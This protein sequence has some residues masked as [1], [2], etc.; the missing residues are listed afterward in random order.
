MG[1]GI[2]FI[3]YFI[4][5]LMSLHKYGFLCRIIGYYLIF[6]SLQKLS[7]YKR[8]LSLAVFPLLIMTLC[9]VYDAGAMISDSVFVLPFPEALSY[10][11]D[12]LEIV[13]SYIFHVLLLRGIMELGN[14]TDLPKVSSFARWTLVGAT[15]YCILNTILIVIQAFVPVGEGS[16]QSFASILARVTLLA[17]I[18]FPMVMLVLIHSCYA[19]ICAPEDVD[20][21]PKPSRFAFINKSRKLSAEKDKEMEA[22]LADQQA[23]RNQNKK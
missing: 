4:A 20:M 13:A 10:A 2:L 21:E 17:G 5:F 16:I 15:A 9:G 8:I 23:K 18:L 19:Q 6:L 3:G 22:W 14:D 12:V 11:I 7:E 1:F